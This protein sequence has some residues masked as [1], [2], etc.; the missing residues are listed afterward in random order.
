M[1]T[2]RRINSGALTLAAAALALP[3]LLQAPACANA[4][5][6]LSGYGAPGQGSQVLLGS[7]LLNGP[8]SGGGSGG[9][10]AGSAAGAAIASERASTGST[11]SS[12]GG[13]RGSVRPEP[14]AHTVAGSSYP[15]AGPLAASA[16]TDPL[17][18]SGADVAFIGLALCMLV[19]TAVL[20]GHLARSERGTRG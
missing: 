19:A 3:A 17:G 18:L 9:P 15:P 13:A 5:P 6:L 2:I 1:T 12:G 8:R 7:T 16:S 14:P 10:R 4:N 20:L 11:G